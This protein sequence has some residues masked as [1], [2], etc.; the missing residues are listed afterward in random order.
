MLSRQGHIKNGIGTHSE[1]LILQG[2]NSHLHCSCCR[3]QEYTSSSAASASEGDEDT[4]EIGIG[5]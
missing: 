2:D 1:Y 4:I 5:T 3:G